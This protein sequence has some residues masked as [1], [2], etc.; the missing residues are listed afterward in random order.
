LG[1]VLDSEGGVERA[2]R[3]RVAATWRKWREIAWLLLN[4]GI[5][6]TSRGTVYEVCLRSVLLYGAENWAL[7]NKLVDVLIRCYRRMLKY[8]ASVT[9]WDRMSSVEVARRC[10]LKQLN[11]VL[12]ARRLKWFGHVKRR[13]E[14]EVLGRVV[15]LVV[16]VQA[17]FWMTESSEL[18]VRQEDRW[19]GGVVRRNDKRPP[20]SEPIDHVPIDHPCGCV[21]DAN[22]QEGN[23]TR[24][25][26]TVTRGC[27]S[28]SVRRGQTQKSE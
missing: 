15:N 27:I 16:T 17:G 11:C 5:S 12:K 21:L 8:M 13:N 25:N 22:H 19:L 3:T 2:V 20:P 28:S 7:A 23:N 24:V 9:M 1:D 10:G 18:N 6:L 14:D 26:Q 4:K